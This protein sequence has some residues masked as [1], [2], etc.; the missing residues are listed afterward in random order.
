MCLQSWPGYA[1]LPVWLFSRSERDVAMDSLEN[2][3]LFLDYLTDTKRKRH[4]V[5]GVLMSVSLFFGGLA[6][7]FM[8]IKGEDNE[9]NDS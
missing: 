1:L 4:V 6:F 8:S 5:G 3:F 7:T 2:V 9:Q